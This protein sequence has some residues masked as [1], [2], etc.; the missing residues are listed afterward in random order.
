MPLQNPYHL[1]LLKSIV[2]LKKKGHYMRELGDNDR[3]W[4]VEWQE[5]EEDGKIKQYKPIDLSSS[6]FGDKFC[7]PFS[8]KKGVFNDSAMTRICNYLEEGLTWSEFC[9]KYPLPKDL[10]EIKLEKPLNELEIQHLK[11]IEKFLF[12]ELNSYSSFDEYWTDKKEGKTKNKREEIKNEVRSINDKM[13]L[14]AFEPLEVLLGNLDRHPNKNDFENHCYYR[15]KKLHHEINQFLENDRLCLIIGKPGNGKTSLGLGVGYDYIKRRSMGQVYY[16]SIEK[17]RGF[18]SWV[19]DITRLDLPNHLFIIDNC[20]LAIN[21]VNVFIGY[22]K[23]IKNASVLLITRKIDSNLSVTEDGNYLKTNL[24][25]KVNIETDEEAIRNI[26]KISFKQ[27]NKSLGDINAICRNCEGDIHILNFFMN[28]WMKEENGYRQLSDVKEE[29]VL[30][31]IYAR[32]LFNKN[33]KEAIFTI[34]ALSQLEIPFEEKLL[35]S[36]SSNTILD[37]SY[38]DILKDAWIERNTTV[39]DG[40]PNSYLQYFHS[41]CAY[42]LVK[43]VWWKGRYNGRLIDLTAE[44]IGNYLKKTPTNFVQ[45]LIYISSVPMMDRYLGKYKNALTLLAAQLYR[46]K[47]LSCELFEKVFKSQAISTLMRYKLEGIYDIVRYCDLCKEEYELEYLEISSSKI[48]ELFCDSID[49]QGLVNWINCNQNFNELYW[50]TLMVCYHE[51]MVEIAEKVDYY[52]FG[53]KCQNY[54]FELFVKN[55]HPICYNGTNKGRNISRKYLSE[56]AVGYGA[57]NAVEGIHKSTIEFF[58]YYLNCFELP[59]SR[60]NPEKTLSTVFQNL[61]FVLLGEKANHT[62]LKTINYVLY[63]SYN[64]GCSLDRLL[65]FTMNIDFGALGKRISK[66]ESSIERSPSNIGPFLEICQKIKVP[67]TKL[68]EFIKEFPRNV[69]AELKENDNWIAILSRIGFT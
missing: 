47:I 50:L 2:Q 36:H 43:S 54:D 3:K 23:Q 30:E 52:G 34:A 40:I 24:F 60:N 6:T 58:E 5:K 13:Q 48:M 32:Y 65:L 7:G 42:F 28:V 18:K 19:K 21:D 20:H 46:D 33:N 62:N 57:L 37:D 61:D 1:L 59:E 8:R 10:P 69:L 66:S 27:S 44:Y 68:I 12:S 45:V 22:F 9:R 31:E 64:R 39:E 51:K 26:V 35:K 41:S 53:K 63:R 16:L 4:L 56:I 55:L 38:D 67:K 11:I 25:N 29:D 15:N 14:E 49:T 17:G